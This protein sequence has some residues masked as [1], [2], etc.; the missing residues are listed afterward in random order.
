MTDWLLLVIIMQFFILLWEL[1]GY[2]MIDKEKCPNCGKE[3]KENDY[4]PFIDFIC[5]DCKESVR[6]VKNRCFWP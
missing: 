1:R 2:G 5:E 6:Y 3:M 4:G